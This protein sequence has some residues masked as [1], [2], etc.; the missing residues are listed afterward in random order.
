MAKGFGMI[1][2]IGQ[3]TLELLIIFVGTMLIVAIVAATVPS[4]AAS[5][6][7][8]RE[9][10]IASGTVNE[11]ASAVDEVYLAGDGSSKQIWIDIP[12]SAALNK[13]FFGARDSET[14]WKKRK[15]I[16]INLLLE[17]DVFAITHAP[18]CGKLPTMA[19]RTLVNVTYNATGTAHVMVNG[20]C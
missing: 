5:T 12:E 6:G 11:V 1:G 3:L 18:T 8:L 13:S 7:A 4:Q 9:K 17:G 15:M 2:K 14:N 19:G 10:F 16:N 20:N